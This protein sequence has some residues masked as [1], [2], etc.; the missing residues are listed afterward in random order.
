VKIYETLH[1]FI[2]ALSKRTN[3]KHGFFD[4]QAVRLVHTS[5]VQYQQQ[6]AQNEDKLGFQPLLIKF[7]NPMNK[8]VSQVIVK[9]VDDANAANIR[10]HFKKE[11]ASTLDKRFGSFMP[12]EFHAYTEYETWEDFDKSWFTREGKPVFYIN[13]PLLFDHI[14]DIE[15]WTRRQTGEKVMNYQRLLVT[16]YF[17]TEN[18]FFTFFIKNVDDAEMSRIKNVVMSRIGLNTEKILSI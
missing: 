6:I 10:E 5:D 16:T 9:G 7:A 17:V 12:E 15:Y 4:D 11:Y 1:D 3:N 13:M 8:K 14:S 2:D 18:K